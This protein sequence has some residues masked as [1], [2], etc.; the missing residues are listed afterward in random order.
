M[1]ELQD[2]VGRIEQRSEFLAPRPCQLLAATVG[3]DSPDLGSPLP[4]LWHWIYFVPDASRDDLGIDGHPRRGAFLPPVQLGRRM[5]AAGSIEYRRP[6]TIG[7]TV[8][9]RNEVI[10]VDE[11][12]GSSGPLVFV[13]TAHEISDDDGVAVLEERT[14]VYTDS[15]P[16]PRARDT[17]EVPSAPWTQDVTTDPV[18]LFRFSALTFNAHRI[19]YDR[20]YARTE[21]GYPDLV[22]HGPLSALL[23]AELA[24]RHAQRVTVFRFRAQAPFYVGDVLYLRGE[25]TPEGAVVMAHRDDGSVGLRATIE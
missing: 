16:A 17:G 25:A 2:W 20:D 24:R 8:T 15:A 14:I 5:F 23:L 3:A 6:L 1:P 4:P 13:R 19:H 18:L 11:K 9:Q 10:A 12:K 21:E 7:T 22:V